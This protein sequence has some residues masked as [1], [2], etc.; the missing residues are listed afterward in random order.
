MHAEAVAMRG[1]F[2]SLIITDA[3][4]NKDN[5]HDV[6]LEVYFSPPSHDRSWMLS[7]GLI[8]VRALW[9]DE[10]RLAS[11]LSRFLT[12]LLSIHG[13]GPEV[14]LKS[15]CVHI[16]SSSVPTVCLLFDEVCVC[17]YRGLCLK[18]NSTT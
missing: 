6:L 7:A 16:S 14:P 12:Q 5:N 4:E 10:S 3:R 18:W 2:P 17:V 11:V 13:K 1:E 15:A 9:G 8:G